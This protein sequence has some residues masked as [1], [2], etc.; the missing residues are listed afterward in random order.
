MTAQQFYNAIWMK[1]AANDSRGD[2]PIRFAEAYAAHVLKIR[3]SIPVEVPP[4]NETH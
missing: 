2:W 4:E 3:E 1:E